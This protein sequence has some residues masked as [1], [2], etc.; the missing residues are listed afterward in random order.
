M[1]YRWER[2]GLRTER[3]ELLYRRLGLDEAGS[4]RPAAAGAGSGGTG[5]AGVDGEARNVLAWIAGTNASDDAIEEIERAACYLAEA[6]TRVAAA[7]VL[8][9]VMGLHWGGAG[10]AA[11]RQAAAGPDP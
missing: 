5:D 11:K 6:H 4:A 2:V 3:Y 8:C 10:A 1:V 9:E 7:K